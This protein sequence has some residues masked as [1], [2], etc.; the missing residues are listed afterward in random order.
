MSERRTLGSQRHLFLRRSA[1]VVEGQGEAERLRLAGSSSRATRRLV[2][3]RAVVRSSGWRRFVDGP[4]FWL[5]RPM[6]TH[7]TRPGRRRRSPPVGGKAPSVKTWNLGARLG[8]HERAAPCARPRRAASAGRALA[9][10]GSP[11]PPRSRSGPAPPAP[12]GWTPASMTITS[13]PSPRP[14]DERTGRRRRATSKARR[15][16]VARLHRRG[17]VEDD[18]DLARSPG[19]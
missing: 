19:P 4:R 18:D 16:H 17:A 12:F 8:R 13:A 10:S 2:V 1:F 11:P 15:R 5:R 9:P 3:E 7:R 14:T 6:P